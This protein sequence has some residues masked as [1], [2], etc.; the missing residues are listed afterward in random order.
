M[1]N[2]AATV[3]AAHAMLVT[4]VAVAVTKRVCRQTS[5]VKHQT[6]ALALAPIRVLGSAVGAPEAAGA[7]HTALATVRGTSMSI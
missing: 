3:Q 7:T 2:S 1:V 4:L 6:L 5:K